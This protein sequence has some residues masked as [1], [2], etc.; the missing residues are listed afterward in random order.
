M[1]DLA[2]VSTLTLTRIAIVVRG[3]QKRDANNRSLLYLIF[4]VKLA[5]GVLGMM[6]VG[7][8]GDVPTKPPL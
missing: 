3:A 6:R 2:L 5:T 7:L 1:V 4:C 8:Q